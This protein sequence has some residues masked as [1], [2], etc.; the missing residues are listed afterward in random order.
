MLVIFPPDGP[1]LPCQDIMLFRTLSLWQQGLL[2]DRRSHEMSA[3]AGH[4]IALSLGRRN[5]IRQIKW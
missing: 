2:C 1:R 4:L 5:C 3:A